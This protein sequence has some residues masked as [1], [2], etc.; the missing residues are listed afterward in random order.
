MSLRTFCLDHIPLTFF[1]TFQ[2]KYD[3]AGPLYERSLAIREKA[4]GPNHPAVAKAL[5]NWAVLLERQ[6][7]PICYSMSSP[8]RTADSQHPAA[9][10]TGQCAEADSLYLRANLI[11]EKTLGPELS[12]LATRVNNWGF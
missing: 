5:N 8:W 9:C 7:R 2:G 12:D 4:L 10:C 6:V 3:E 11:G 1:I